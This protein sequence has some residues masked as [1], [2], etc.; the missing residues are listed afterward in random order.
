MYQNK[1]SNLECCKWCKIRKGFFWI[2]EFAIDE[3]TEWILF[4]FLIFCFLNYSICV[5]III[6]RFNSESFVSWLES[7][8]LECIFKSNIIVYLTCSCF[9]ETKDWCIFESIECKWFYKDFE[10]ILWIHCL[11]FDDRSIKWESWSKINFAKFS[12]EFFSCCDWFDNAESIIGRSPAS[13]FWFLIHH[14]TSHLINYCLMFSQTLSTKECHCLNESKRIRQS[15]ICSRSTDKWSTRI[16]DYILI[17]YLSNDILCLSLEFH[18]LSIIHFCEIWELE[19]QS[20]IR[21]RPIN[22]ICIDSWWSILVCFYIILPYFIENDLVHLICFIITWIT[23]KHSSNHLYSLRDGISTWWSITVWTNIKIER[24][25]YILGR[26]SENIARCYKS[27][28]WETAKAWNG[29][30]SEPEARWTRIMPITESAIISLI[31]THICENFLY[32]ILERHL[33]ITFLFW[34]IFWYHECRE[35]IWN[36]D[37]VMQFLDIHLWHNGSKFLFE[38]TVWV[39]GKEI[40]TW[41]E[42]WKECRSITNINESSV[43]SYSTLNL[44]LFISSRVWPSTRDDH[45][46]DSCLD[47][48]NRHFKTVLILGCLW[49]CLHC[50]LGC[51][52]S[53]LSDLINPINYN[54]EINWYLLSWFDHDRLFWSIDGNIVGLKCDIE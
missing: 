13:I 1:F 50:N 21:E 36:I 20:S 44:N 16:I 47:Y 27:N 48:W 3:L 23:R 41:E 30:E 17:S 42:S 34:Y 10:F 28:I 38:T 12:C 39:R 32:C 46:S 52:W 25:F 26:T 43:T 11:W 8:C 40:K 31:R 14:P 45:F 49:N 9:F 35:I 15:R 29:R 18:L 6:H 7:T 33:F 37:T 54:L 53:E 22:T 24:T 5:V 51:L 2:F 19:K 4:P